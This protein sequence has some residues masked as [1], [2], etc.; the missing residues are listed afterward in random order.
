MQ[1]GLMQRVPL[2]L[3]M[4]RERVEALY[5]A[6]TVTTRY[7][8]GITVATY[9]RFC[10]ARR[11]W[12]TFLQAVRSERRAGGDA[13]VEFAAAPRTLSRGALHGCGASHRQCPAFRVRHRETSRPCRG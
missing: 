6:K 7:A 12:P 9:G 8:C 1:T 5:P 11:G 4:I 3:N 13:G 10:N 2:T